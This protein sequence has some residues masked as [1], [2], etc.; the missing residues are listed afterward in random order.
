MLSLIL[1]LIAGIIMLLSG[2][3]LFMCFFYW[4]IVN[5][6]IMKTLDLKN[7]I[8]DFIHKELPVIISHIKHGANCKAVYMPAHIEYGKNANRSI[9]AEIGYY[10]WAYDIFMGKVPMIKLMVFCNFIM[11]IIK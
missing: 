6:G 9:W 2:V 3:S 4:N 11:W 1:G 10:I 5:G 8:M 7:K